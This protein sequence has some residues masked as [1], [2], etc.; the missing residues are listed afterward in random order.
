MKLEPD[1]NFNEE[2]KNKMSLND[3]IKDIFQNINSINID[4]IKI[5]KKIF[6]KNIEQYLNSE[7]I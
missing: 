3:E 4:E 7:K 5:A 2:I 1:E 6:E